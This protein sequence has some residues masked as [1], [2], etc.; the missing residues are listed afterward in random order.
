M[1]PCRDFTSFPDRPTNSHINGKGSERELL[2][3]MFGGPV[4][5]TGENTTYDPILYLHHKMGLQE[6]PI[7]IF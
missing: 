5:K 4:S 3:K 6:Y 2:I 1:G 7:D